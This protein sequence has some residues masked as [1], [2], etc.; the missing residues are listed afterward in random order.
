MLNTQL[1]THH[2]P[3]NLLS[4]VSD[5]ARY[6]EF[7]PWIKAMRVSNE[8]K[9]AAEEFKLGEAVVGFKGFTERF[10]TNVKTNFNDKTVSVNLVRGPFKKLVNAWTFSKLENG[11]SRIEFHIDYEFSNPILRMLASSNTE[12]VVQRVIAA[13]VTEADRRYGAA[14]KPSIS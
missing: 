4:L 13:F 5:I 10:A 6:P 7:I 12:A 2:T 8:R 9:D 11:S 1:E 14:S 3:D